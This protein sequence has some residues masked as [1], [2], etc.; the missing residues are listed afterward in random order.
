MDRRHCQK[1]MGNIEELSEPEGPIKFI[2]YDR[3]FEK[4]LTKSQNLMLYMT[5]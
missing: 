2:K 4:Q 1:S 3:L 5:S